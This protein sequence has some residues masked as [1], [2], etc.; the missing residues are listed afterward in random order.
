MFN[1]KSCSSFPTFYFYQFSF[2]CHNNLLD[3]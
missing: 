1:E 3:I 2:I